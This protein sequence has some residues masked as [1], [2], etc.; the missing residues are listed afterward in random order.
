MDFVGGVAVEVHEL[1]GRYYAHHDRIFTLSLRKILPIPAL[2][3]RM[4]YRTYRESLE[5]IHQ[6]LILAADSLA[7]HRNCG[8]RLSDHP[9]GPELEAYARQVADSARRLGKVC[10]GLHLKTEARPR[11]NAATYKSDVAAYDASVEIYRV[12]GRRLNRSFAAY[13]K[14]RDAS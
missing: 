10:L 2:V 3:G 4:N 8:E 12:T 14:A 9:F 11:F 7:R 6:D 1:L 5:S 13:R